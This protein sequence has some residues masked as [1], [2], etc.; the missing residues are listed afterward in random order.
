MYFLVVHQNWFLVSYSPFCQFSVPS[1]YPLLII[2]TLINNSKLVIINFCNYH[3][4][5]PV[6]DGLSLLRNNRY[7]HEMSPH[8]V[9]S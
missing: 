3:L 6:I 1:L 8:Y 7:C 2:H 4:G 5:A 9:T